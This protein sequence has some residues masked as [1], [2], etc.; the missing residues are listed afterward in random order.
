MMT[1]TELGNTHNYELF[2][3]GSLSDPYPLLDSLRQKD[4]IHWSELL[5]GWV[6][7]RYEDVFNAFLDTR[8]SSQKAQAIMNQLPSEQQER[9]KSLGTHL[10]LWVSHNDPPSH[11]RLRRLINM[12]FTPRVINTMAP[13]I[14]QVVDELIDKVFDQGKMDLIKDFAY[15]LPV[16]VISEML[17]VPSQDRSQ[18]SNWI[19]DIVLTMDGSAPEARKYAELSQKSLLELINYFNGIIN[20]RRREPRDDLI[21]SLIAVEEEGDRLSPNELYAMVSQILVGGHDTT[22]GLIGNSIL[23][24]LQFP[25]EMKKLKGNPSLI[26]TAVEEFLRFEAPGPRNTRL[27]RSNLEIGGQQIKKGE[28]L[29]LMVNAA[30]HDPAKFENPDR[31]DITRHPNNHLTFGWGLHFCLGAPLA[32][33]EGKIAVNA[34][35]RRLPDL[36]FADEPHRDTPPWRQS[37]GLRLLKTLPVEF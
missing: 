36:H 1:D 3:H 14:E 25:D 11:T 20:Q 24:L 7:T 19:D 29:F 8:L 23:A 15:A 4:P 22:T 18:F 30:N 27:A 16:T 37:A 33:L 6:L 31:I 13:Q 9:V 35:L 28:T 5:G 10:A 12:A 21:S 32:R 2:C 26:N 17:G 34:L